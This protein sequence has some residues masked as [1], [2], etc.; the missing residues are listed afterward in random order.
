MDDT[1]I[2]RQREIGKQ[3]FLV[4]ILHSEN[5]RVRKGGYSFI[6]RDELADWASISIDE[7][8]RF[9]DICACLDPTNMVINAADN[10]CEN[11]TF[12]NKRNVRWFIVSTYYR[13]GALFTGSLLIDKFNECYKD[14]SEY[15][16]ERYCE[17]HEEKPVDELFAT[18]EVFEE[19]MV[20]YIKYFLSAVKEVLSEGY[21]WD[22]VA[23]MTRTDISEERY[24]KLV[25][26]F[27]K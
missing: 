13:M 7:L 27:M 18:P 3:L 9:I 2:K 21:D 11:D 12:K 16:Y 19:I 14:M 6:D 24:N 26:L 4:N 23:A 22:V 10:Y 15:N 8:N 5:D 17:I 25:N 1:N 20:F